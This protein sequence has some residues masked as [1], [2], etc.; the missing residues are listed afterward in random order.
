MTA[1]LKSVKCI[2]NIKVFLL[3]KWENFAVD[4]FGAEVWANESD[5]GNVNNG[6]F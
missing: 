6:F 3:R 4:N 1:L 2:Q 5:S